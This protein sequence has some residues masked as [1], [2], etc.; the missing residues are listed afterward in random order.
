MLL[1]LTRSPMWAVALAILSLVVLPKPAS[2]DTC[3]EVGGYTVCCKDWSTGVDCYRMTPAPEP[4]PEPEPGPEPPGI[5]EPPEGPVEHC[6]YTGTL[7]LGA[8]RTR[9]EMT[10]VLAE[11]QCDP[12]GRITWEWL[13]TSGCPVADPADPPPVDEPPGVVR[14]RALAQI[15][16]GPVAWDVAP[17]R[18]VVGL[19]VW[20]SIPESEFQVRQASDTSR[21]GTFTVTV[22]AT[23]TEV[24]WTF[25]DREFRCDGPGTTWT[26]AGYDAVMATGGE[27][28]GTPHCAIFFNDSSSDI[29]GRP[30][31]SGVT[32]NWDYSWSLN[33]M[34]MGTFNTLQSPEAS[35]D[36]EVREL[37]AVIT[38]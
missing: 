8:V 23:P 35:F 11:M 31:P 5:P 26:R 34:D 15:D 2:A 32:V 38:D 9:G 4:E 10:E 30:L 14:E 7:R 29:A 20:L 27:M 25:G 12:S 37:Q 17:D 19:P 33:G 1:K 28:H 6:Y 18:G 36:L 22:T 21:L 24:I 3:R 16:L 13:C